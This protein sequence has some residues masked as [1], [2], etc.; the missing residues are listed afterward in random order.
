VD[1]FL[2]INSC[3]DSEI[4]PLPSFDAYYCMNEEQLG[5]ADDASSTTDI[6]DTMQP[7]TYASRPQQFRSVNYVFFM[8]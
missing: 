5:P 3:S 1:F 6:T 8:R 7:C 4:L 2:I